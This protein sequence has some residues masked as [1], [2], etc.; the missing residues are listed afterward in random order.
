MHHQATSV[1]PLNKTTHHLAQLPLKLRR[2]LN[3]AAIELVSNLSADMNWF[4]ASN[5]AS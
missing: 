2:P 5:S 1:T 4:A 3:T